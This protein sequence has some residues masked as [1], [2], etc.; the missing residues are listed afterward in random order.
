ML[1][2]KEHYANV[3]YCNFENTMD[4]HT[5]FERNLDPERIISALSAM[6]NT[7]ISKGNTLL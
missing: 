3:V 6:Y 4:L 1:F 7:E 5:I 2:G